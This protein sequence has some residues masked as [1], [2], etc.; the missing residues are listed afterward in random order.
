M[1][2]SQHM[3]SSRGPFS[4]Y[5]LSRTCSVHHDRLSCVDSTQPAEDRLSCVDSTQ[6]AELSR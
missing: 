1:A 3:H 4:P 5:I 2:I 6:P